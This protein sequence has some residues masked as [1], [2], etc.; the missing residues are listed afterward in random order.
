MGEE[1]DVL[2][3][4][5]EAGLGGEGRPGEL[6]D[7]LVALQELPTNRVPVRTP[8]IIRIQIG[9]QLGEN[10]PERKVLRQKRRNCQFF[11]LEL[12]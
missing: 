3:D 1:L 2:E 5:G 12:V 11:L 7:D 10:F 8:Q 9:R 4:L 6:V